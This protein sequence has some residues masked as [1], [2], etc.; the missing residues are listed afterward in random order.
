M[1]YPIRSTIKDRGDGVAE[2]VLCDNR[3]VALIDSSDI[4][5]VEPFNWCL[6]IRKKPTADYPYVKASMRNA[7][8][9]QKIILLHRF[10]LSIVDTTIEVDH[11]DGDGLNNRRGNLRACTHRQNQ[12]NQ[13]SHCGKSRFK[14]LGFI[15]SG[16]GWQAQICVNYQRIYLGFFKSEVDAAKA[17]DVAAVKYFGEFARLNFPM[18]G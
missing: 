3:A 7:E 5:L 4:P 6:Q 15:K 12:A 18:E 8:G 14:G 16:N 10:L 13:R 17:Y 9:W 1:R 11:R 2:I